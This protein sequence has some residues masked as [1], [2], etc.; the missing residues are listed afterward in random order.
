MDN[1]SLCLV[2]PINGFLCS[3][4]GWAFLYTAVERLSCYLLYIVLNV[5]DLDFGLL[6]PW[7]TWNSLWFGRF[8]YK[9]IYFGC[10]FKFYKM[11]INI[12]LTFWPHLKSRSLVYFD[13]ETKFSIFWIFVILSL[14]FLEGFSIFALPCASAKSFVKYINYMFCSICYLEPPPS[15]F[16]IL[17]VCTYV[18]QIHK[19]HDL[20]RK[21]F[22]LY[23]MVVVF[24]IST[25]KQMIKKKRD[26]WN[27]YIL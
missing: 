5:F 14:P 18:I 20:A 22:F 6:F 2:C 8:W 1:Y 15:E 26:K 23:I 27:N 7:Q 12:V 13:C 25:T 19:K 4:Q 3:Y 17:F 16:V 21:L 24:Y 10:L 11:Y 9:S